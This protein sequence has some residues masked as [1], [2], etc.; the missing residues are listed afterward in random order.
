M[1]ARF[2]M[3]PGGI[4]EMPDHGRCFGRLANID[5]RLC[6]GEFEIVF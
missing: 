6:P 1:K 5:A 2:Q 3:I 4:D